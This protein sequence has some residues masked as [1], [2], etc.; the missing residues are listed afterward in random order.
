M[1]P[2]ETSTMF[3]R[4][5]VSSATSYLADERFWT[6]VLTDT[7]KNIEISD[8]SLSSEDLGIESVSFRITKNTLHGGKQEGSTLIGI[9]T[10]ALRVTVIPTRGM[11]VLEASSGDVEL[12]WSSPVDE[13]VHPSFINLTQRGG[14]GW[15]DGFNE[16]L[17]RCGF[18]WA[19]HPSDEDGT[20]YTLHGKSGNTPASMVVVQIE[21]RIPHK[22]LVHGLVKEKTFKFVDLEVMTSLAV[23]PGASC[24]EVHDCVTNQADYER[25]VEVIYH[26]NFGPPLLEDGSRVLAPVSEVSPFND[27]AVTGLET[28]NTYGPPTKGF[29]EMLF[30][31]DLL[32]NAKDETLAA[33]INAGGTRGVAMRYHPSQMPAFT[34]WKNTDTLKQGYVTGLEPG[35]N[36]PY[37]RQ[38]ERQCGRLRTLLPKESCHFD[39]TIE[40]LRSSEDV[41][42]IQREVDQIADGQKGKISHRQKRLPLDSQG[43]L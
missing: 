30:N 16:L 35:T 29:D 37:Q 27:Q 2:L 25:E 17:V 34:L 6:Y 40:V 7:V 31:C 11:S 12:G 13:I 42:R 33:L 10:D 20:L 43:N 39:L 14:L 24:F 28:W 9:E 21:K 5:A 15:L 36:H 38:V 19:G 4:T 23:T 3:N 41:T 32:G 1:E 22:I 8:W 26:A 18:E